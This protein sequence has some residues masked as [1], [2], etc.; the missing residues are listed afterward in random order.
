MRVGKKKKEKQ[1]PIN[2]APFED[3]F[4][5]LSAKGRIRRQSSALGRPRRDQN[6]YTFCASTQCCHTQ[7]ATSFFVLYWIDDMVRAANRALYVAGHPPLFKGNAVRPRIHHLPQTGTRTNMTKNKNNN[8]VLF[9]PLVCALTLLSLV[10]LC[11]G[12]SSADSCGCPNLES[13]GIDYGDEGCCAGH[14]SVHVGDFSPFLFNE[15]ASYAALGSVRAQF[16]STLPHTP[17]DL[18]ETVIIVEP[19][20]KIMYQSGVGYQGGGKN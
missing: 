6:A 16:Y 5:D 9:V 14:T 15:S 20:K 19:A 7:P 2:A 11:A 17:T 18:F 3:F 8:N 13:D 4:F 10:C 1:H 12:A